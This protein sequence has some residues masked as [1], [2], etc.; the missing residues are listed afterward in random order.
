MILPKGRI[1][2]KIKKLILSISSAAELSHLNQRSKIKNRNF[3]Y[4]LPWHDLTGSGFMLT[5]EYF[6]NQNSSQFNDIIFVTCGSSTSWM[7]SKLLKAQRDLHN[8][9]SKINIIKRKYTQ[10]GFWNHYL[11]KIT[12][13]HDD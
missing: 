8:K 6:G 2:R 1:S 7:N 5:L 10:K 12:F 9:Q 3:I 13:R 4:E 11:L